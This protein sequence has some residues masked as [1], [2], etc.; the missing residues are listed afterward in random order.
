ML[1]D[2]TEAPIELLDVLLAVMIPDPQAFRGLLVEQVAARWPWRR[3]RPCKASSFRTRQARSS[4]TRCRAGNV[5]VKPL[6]RGKGCGINGMNGRNTNGAAAFLTPAPSPAEGSSSFCGLRRCRE[7]SS[8]GLGLP[9]AAFTHQP[10]PNP[11][12]RNTGHAPRSSIVISHCES[13]QPASSGC[14][15]WSGRIR[16][17]AAQG[18]S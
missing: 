5:A 8:S 10:L 9:D 7:G 14:C 6:P 3:P 15:P 4:R 16:G 11:V 17:A 18:C 2:R 1:A 12:R 13:P